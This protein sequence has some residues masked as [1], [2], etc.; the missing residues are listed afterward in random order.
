MTPNRFLLLLGVWLLVCSPWGCGRAEP[1]D[2]P[3]PESHEDGTQDIKKDGKK[4]SMTIQDNRPSLGNRPRPIILVHRGLTTKAPENTVAAVQAALDLGADGVEVDL[5]ITAD[6]EVVVFHD[7]DLERLTGR[8]GKV[9]DHRLVELEKIPLLDVA[10]GKATPHTIVGLNAF[11]DRFGG[12]CFLFLELKVPGGP[13]AEPLREKLVERVGKTL[14]QRKLLDS[15][16]VSSLDVGVLKE[17]E[18]I[19]EP[20]RSVFEFFPPQEALAA[21][22]ADIPRSLPRTDWIGPNYMW[23]TRDR[24]IWARKHYQ[25][26]SVFT[27]NI[28]E[29]QIHLVACGVDLIQTDAPQLALLC[30][31]KKLDRAGLS[32]LQQTTSQV[33]TSHWPEP[34][35]SFPGTLHDQGAL[36]VDFPEGQVLTF[37]VP[38]VAEKIN[39]VRMEVERL[40]RKQGGAFSIS[41]LEESEMGSPDLTLTPVGQVLTRGSRSWGPHLRFLSLPDRGRLEV[42]VTVMPDRRTRSLFVAVGTAEPG[43]FRLHGLKT[44]IIEP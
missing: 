36:D 3:D 32:R 15:T 42:S 18:R 5:Q 8:K 21:L 40:D 10:T 22:P 23:I 13:R 31:E 38:A 43:R 7:E 16:L 19:H 34:P 11:L 4:D 39:F 37:S 20:V 41:V 27:P 24:V 29:D 28:L 44:G 6:H 35:A 12:K 1:L 9:Q 30:R 14:L 17:L 2:S 26:I 25:G 33:L